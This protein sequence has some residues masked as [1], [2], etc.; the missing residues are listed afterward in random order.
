MYS[1]MNH[2]QPLVRTPYATAHMHSEMLTVDTGTGISY[3]SKGSE[4]KWL[5]IAQC[6]ESTEVRMFGF[7][8][9]TREREKREERERKREKKG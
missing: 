3:L 8:S 9:A 2:H 5:G 7:F 1:S 6:T 4:E